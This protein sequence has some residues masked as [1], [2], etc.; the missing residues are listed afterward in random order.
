MRSTTTDVD[1]E[2]VAEDKLI[3]RGLRSGGG[4]CGAIDRGDRPITGAE[5]EIVIGRVDLDVRRDAC[6]GGHIPQDERGGSVN[7]SGTVVFSRE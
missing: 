4:V 3:A 7:I 2:L 6:C 1:G 5:A